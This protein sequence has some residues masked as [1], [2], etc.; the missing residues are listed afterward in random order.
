MLSVPAAL[1]PRL[2]SP[3]DAAAKA[4]AAAKAEAE[5]KAKA[6]ATAK[7][8]AEVRQTSAALLVTAT[9]CLHSLAML[10][11]HTNGVDAAWCMHDW[12][13]STAGFTLSNCSGQSRLLHNKNPTGEDSS[14][15]YPVVMCIAGEGYGCRRSVRKG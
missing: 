7:A 3:A 13:L 11:H 15:D 10:E 5:A 14:L 9:L 2:L 6:A 1:L 12:W 4:S 8:E